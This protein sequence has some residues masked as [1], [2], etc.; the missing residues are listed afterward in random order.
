MKTNRGIISK[1]DKQTCQL[2]QQIEHFS[3]ALGRTP[4]A[5]EVREQQRRSVPQPL[6]PMV[7]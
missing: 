6:L 3:T 2:H 1:P 4:D 7:F 5:R